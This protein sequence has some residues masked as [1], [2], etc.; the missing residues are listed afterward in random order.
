MKALK[1][2]AVLL[3]VGLALLVVALNIWGAFTLGG[4]RPSA[5][6]PVHEHA[7]QVVMVFGATGSVGDGLLKAAMADPDVEKV[8][9]VTRRSS[10]RIEAGVAQGE[11]ELRLHED[12]TDYSALADILG[13]VNTVMWGLGTTSLGMDDETYTRIHVDFPVAFVSAWLAARRDGPMAFHYVTGMGTDSDGAQHWAREKG[14]A[15][16]EVAALAEGSGLRT[17]GHRSAFIRPSSEQANAMHYLLEALLR[18]GALVIAS[19]EL[20]GAMLEIS[21]RTSELPNGA[22]IDNADGIA[23]AQAYRAR[24]SP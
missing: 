17:F 7:N 14:R 20:G 19:D 2:L 1:K 10:P 12:F 6:A 4:L 9:V 18:P 16:R 5:N 15:E 3:L 8:Y 23:Y 24:Q 11:I 21:A 22:I 13:E